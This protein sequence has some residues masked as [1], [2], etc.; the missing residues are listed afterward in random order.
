LRAVAEARSFLKHVVLAAAGV[1]ALLFFAI[2]LLDPYGNSPLRLV[3]RQPIMDINQRYMYP[4][5]ARS[6]AYDSVVI[7]TST[8]RLLD[9]RALDAAFGGRFANLAMNAG[10][11]WEQAE[12]A[13]LYLRHNPAPKTFILGLDQVWCLPEGAIERITFRGFPEWMYDENPLNDLPELFNLKTLEIAGRVAAFHLR[14][15][16]ERIRGDG[17]EVFTPPETSYDLARARLHIW[18][19]RPG[20]RIMPEVPAH[21]L[22]EAE[23]QALV[24]PAIAWLDDLLARLPAGRQRLLVYMPLH[25]AAQPTPGSRIAAQ[26]EFCKARIDA[27]ASRRGARVVDFA[28]DSPVTREDSN[29][30][31]PL[32]YRLPIADRIIAGMKAAL[33]TGADDAAGLYLVRR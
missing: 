18:R 31:D 16:P 4:R 9:P 30:W 20:A 3:S 7:G 27:V 14:L 33:E 24:F 15:M 19:D 8:S 5:I 6:K 28:V 10:T 21:A 22:T 2:L 32:H 1:A 29:Y 11:A 13:K 17:Y 12:L 23:A 26:V 25:V